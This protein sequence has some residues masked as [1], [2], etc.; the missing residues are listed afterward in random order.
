VLLRLNREKK[1]LA[2]RPRDLNLISD[3]QI[4]EIVAADTHEE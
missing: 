2:G 1:S 4:T 3:L